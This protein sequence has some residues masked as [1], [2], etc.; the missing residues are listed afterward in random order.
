MLIRIVAAITRDGRQGVLPKD[1]LSALDMPVAVVWGTRDPV[2][3]FSQALEVPPHFKLVVA[4]E[5]GHMLL[6]ERPDLSLAA[7]RA[8]VGR[9]A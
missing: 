7:I 6:E 3:P 1:R 2:L 5:A 9:Q 4:E 8:T